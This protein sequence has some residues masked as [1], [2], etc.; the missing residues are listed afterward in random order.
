MDTRI[1]P[2]PLHNTQTPLELVC[3]EMS[4]SLASLNPSR[5]N[6]Y[7]RVPKPKLPIAH[8]GTNTGYTCTQTATAIE[9]RFG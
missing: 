9:N 5:Q 7:N 3:R 6:K 1:P 8:M 4:K 2:A